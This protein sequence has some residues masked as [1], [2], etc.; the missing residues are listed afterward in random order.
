MAAITYDAIT[1]RRANPNDIAALQ[2]TASAC[3]W[4][5][6]QEILPASFIESFLTRA[7][8]HDRLLAQVSDPNTLFLVVTA[9]HELDRGSGP[10][11]NEVVGEVIV[12]FGQV[13][14][15]LPR[16]DDA[17]VAPADLHRLYLLS[18]WQRHGIGSRL[19]GEL[20]AWVHEQGHLTYGAYVHSRNEP[21][22]HFYA[23]QGF[24]HKAE[25]DVQDEWYLVKSLGE[26]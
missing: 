2:S 9:H 21:A 16:L 23:R 20:E 10:A 12:G 6:Y 25:C 13:G 7:Y 3:W 5:T 8:R 15:P 19:L 24:V 1:I 11:S 17:P 14:P 18:A 22:K 4:A 26:K